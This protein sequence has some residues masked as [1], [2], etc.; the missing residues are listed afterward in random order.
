[1]HKA[2]LRKT[3]GGGGGADASAAPSAEPKS[4]LEAA[5]APP[6]LWHVGWEDLG[7]MPSRPAASGAWLL[8]A[9]GPVLLEPAWELGFV[10]VLS[11]CGVPSP[12][13]QRNG[14]AEKHKQD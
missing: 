2:A 9:T 3:D 6:M 12:V 14:K 4:P 7:P 10:F 1:M 13:A 11:V 8:I 5:G